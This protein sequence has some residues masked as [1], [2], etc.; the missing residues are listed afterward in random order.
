MGVWDRIPKQIFSTRGWGL[1]AAGL[2]CLLAAQVLGRRDLLSD[3]K[4]VV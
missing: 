4:S 1:L 3:R 2:L